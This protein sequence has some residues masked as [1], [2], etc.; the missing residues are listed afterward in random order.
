MTAPL[1]E[2]SGAAASA[3]GPARSARRADGAAPA[4]RTPA[5]AGAPSP[6]AFTIEIPPRT[7][8]LN[9]NDRPNHFARARIVKNLRTIAHQLAVIRR[10]PHLDRV[11]ITGFVHPPDNRARDP[12]NWHPTLKAGIDG[13][14]DAGVITDDSSRFVVRT[15]MLLGAKARFLSFSF[16]IRELP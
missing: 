4:G 5:G 14:R 1:F 15:D 3:A 8:L 16:E 10:I 7:I 12:H 11:E 13:I 9:A 6:R 2:I